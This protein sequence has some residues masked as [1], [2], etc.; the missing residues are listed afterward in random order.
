MLDERRNVGGRLKAKAHRLMSA[1]EC[2]RRYGRHC[3]T[4]ELYGTIVGVI[5][6]R[7]NANHISTTVTADYDL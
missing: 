1:S 5:E 2:S 6:S 3:K 7:T 4:K